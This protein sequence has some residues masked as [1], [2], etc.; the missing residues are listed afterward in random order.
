MILSHSRQRRGSP[1]R[2]F[3]LFTFFAIARLQCRCRWRI[4]YG[5]NGM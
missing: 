1:G 2:W 4:V 5:Q 3:Q